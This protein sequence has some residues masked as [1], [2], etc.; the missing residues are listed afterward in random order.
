MAGRLL[1]LILLLPVASFAADQTMERSRTR[2][3]DSFGAPAAGVIAQTVIST[4]YSDDESIE[5]AAPDI[6]YGSPSSPF[7]GSLFERSNLTGDWWGARESLRERGITFDVSATQFYQGITSGGINQEF[8]YGGRNDYLFNLDGE[9]AG[10]WNGLHINLH[11]ETRY[12]TDI[13]DSSG[14]LLVPPNIA[15]LFPLPVGSPSAL[16]TVKATQYLSDDVVI[17]GGKFNMLDELIQPFGAGRG[18]DAFMNTGLVFPVV[19][20]RTVPYSTLGAG[21]AILS[22]SRAVFTLMAFDPHNTPTTSGFE[23]FFTNGAVVLSKLDIPVHPFGLPGHQGVEG[24][25]STGTYES[26]RTIPYID[27]NG[28]PSVSTAS[29]RGSWSVFYMA[30]QAL[31][32]DPNNPNRSWGVFTNIGIAD[33]DP[34]PVRWSA[35]FGLGGS[36]PLVSRPLDTFGIG[37]SFVAPSKGLKQLDPQFLPLRSDHAIELFYNMAVTPWFRLTPDL[38]ILVPGIERTPPPG[39]QPIDTAVIVGLRAKI[40]F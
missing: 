7:A 3:S 14:S 4:A 26:L 21:F 6:W 31:Y 8:E 12:G 10:L 5:A 13:N 15:S 16:T 33:N 18:V 1:F 36:S 29:I 27:A 19:L 37:Y 2:D 23:S 34:S 11:G 35:S 17:F 22:G 40:D 28:L 30:D 38:Q 24:T 25:Y 20:E 32:V 9:K 39:A